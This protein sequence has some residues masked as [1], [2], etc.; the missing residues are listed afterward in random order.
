MDPDT[1]LA[2]SLKKVLEDSQVPDYENGSILTGAAFRFTGA[3]PI[4]ENY[5]RSTD[6]NQTRTLNPRAF[7]SMPWLWA[8]PAYEGVRTVVEV[9]PPSAN[10]G[11]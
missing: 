1:W 6:K 8:G 5:S 10:M 7:V 9:K 2:Y 11:K 4:V 3:I